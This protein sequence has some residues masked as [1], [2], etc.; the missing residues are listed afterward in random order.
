[1]WRRAIS[2]VGALA[3]MLPACGGRTAPR[4]PEERQPLAAGQLAELWADPGQTPRDLFWGVGGQVLAPDPDAA[5]RLDS[6]DDSGFSVSYD[7][8]GPG[9][10][11]W[12]AKIGPEAQTEV[13]VSRILWGIGY[14]QPPAYYLPSWRLETGDGE[15]QESEARFRPKVPEF[16]SNSEIWRWADNPFR[17]TREFR[18]LLV[19]LLMVNST[20]LKDG[21]NRIYEF[22]RPRD[23]A[24]RWFVV[25]DLGA[26]LGETGKLYPRR[27]W[28]EGFEA[29]GFIRRV[30]DEGVEFDF[31]GRHQDLLS[32]VTPADVRWAAGRLDRLTDRQ[33]RD[34][35]RAGNYAPAVAERYIRRLRQKIAEGL[36]LKGRAPAPAAVERSN[37]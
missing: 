11:E 12:S 19:A 6:R 21:N 2:T 24:S 9:G 31:E 30:S 37:E 33:W 18:G 32:L 29:G 17:G 16:D 25:R 22:E 10:V 4:V 7:V 26:S 5:F 34:A 1:M 35:F 13:V 8:H 20:D 3:L 15:R 28:L 14:R 23:G 27:N 36:A